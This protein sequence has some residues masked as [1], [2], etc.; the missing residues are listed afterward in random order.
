MGLATTKSEKKSPLPLPPLSLPPPLS[1][2]NTLF[3]I[4]VC[5]RWLTI[6]YRSK[7]GLLDE[8]KS[9]IFAQTPFGSCLITQL[10]LLNFK[11][12]FLLL[13]SCVLEWSTW[14]VW[15][16]LK[17]VIH[18]NTTSRVLR[19]R[20]IVNSRVLLKPTVFS[21]PKFTLLVHTAGDWYQVLDHDVLPP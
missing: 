7:R 9:C 10:P 19:V 13:C 2:S 21:C 12:I 16:L 8:A 3:I 6:D 18:P 15:I 17:Q 11:L 5:I 1:V 4:S 14:P 20:K